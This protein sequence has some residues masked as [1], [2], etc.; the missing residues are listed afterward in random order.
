MDKTFLII[1]II[2]IATTLSGCTGSHAT[3]SINTSQAQVQWFEHPD[4]NL[5]AA[6]MKLKFDRNDI[7]AGENV[8]ADL[9]VLNAGTENITDETVEIKAKVNTLDDFLA[10]LYLKTMSDEK[11]T[12]SETIDFDSKENPYYLIKPGEKKKL[13]AVFPTEKERQGKSLAGTYDVTVTLSVNGQKIEARTFPITLLSGE[14]REFSPTPTSSST[15]TPTPT[16][17]PTI[18]ATP[19]PTPTPEIVATPT[20]VSKEVRVVPQDKFAIN[21]IQINAGDEIVWFNREEDSYTIVELNKKIGNITLS[22]RAN[23]TFTKAGNYSFTLVKS[24]LR[25]KPIL[26]V[27]VSVNESK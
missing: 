27:I 23:Y 22:N 18:T 13:S 26:N 3:T 17:A 6:V 2:L 19:T 15:P 7:R 24:G 11:K 9:M 1:L 12:G 5:D 4:P 21:Q 25:T 16:L 14:T 10:N 20:G 8:T